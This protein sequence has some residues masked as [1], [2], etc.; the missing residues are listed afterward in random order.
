M[1]KKTPGEQRVVSRGGLPN[2]SRVGLKPH[3]FQDIYHYALR[4][5][6][7]MLLLMIAGLYLAANALFALVFMMCGGISNAR[8][9]SFA[10]AFFFSVQTMATIGYG[11][12]WPTT[13]LAEILVTAEA[14]V[15]LLGLAVATGLIFSKFSRPTARI[16]FSNVAVIAPRDGVPSLMFRMANERQDQIVEATLRLALIRNEQTAEGERLRRI[17]DLKLV[18]GQSAVFFLSWTAIHPITPDSPLYGQTREDL[19]KVEAQVM[20]TVIGTDETLAQTI[21]A[22]YAYT[23]ADLVWG[24]RLA[25]IISVDENGRRTVDYSRFHDT[26]PIASAAPTEVKA[27]AVHA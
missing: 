11:Q 17:H 12:M 8:P 20:A 14:M 13:V 10:D 7:S 27:G 6:W 21:H 5:P 2:V 22:R 4:A 15:G 18:R 23:V 3:L 26:L 19:A 9:G 24:H 25:D 1:A 16:M